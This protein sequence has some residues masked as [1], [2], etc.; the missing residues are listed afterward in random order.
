MG[1]PAK[2]LILS[3]KILSGGQKARVSLARAVYSRASVLLLDDVISAVDAQTSKHIVQ[4]C[5]NSTLMEGRTIIIASHA[6]EALAPLAGH[7]VFL[8][9]GRAVWTGTGADLLESQ[10]MNHLKTSFSDDKIAGTDEND[11][12][13]QKAIE[14]KEDNRPKD[15]VSKDKDTFEIKEQVPKTPKQLIMEEARNK[16]SID[17]K[18]WKDLKRFNGNNFF[19]TGLITFLFLSALSPVAERRALEYVVHL[20]LSR[21]T[22]A[23]RSLKR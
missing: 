1:L 8:D 3:G 9:D 7:A 11:G 12:K 4:H 20:F 22:A 17:A 16:N 14:G 10:H 19:W 6:V 21:C 5:F 13:G 23:D 2:R 15:E 18:H